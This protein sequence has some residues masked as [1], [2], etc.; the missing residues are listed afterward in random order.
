MKTKISFLAALIIF[1]TTI[2]AAI[3][4][5]M[6]DSKKVAMG[7][8]LNYTASWGGIT[9]GSATTKID[10][11]V[12]KLGAKNCYKIDV[13]GKTNGLARLFYVN[14]KWTSYIDTATVMTHKTFRSV[15]EGRYELDE[16]VYFD[17]KNQ[18]ADVRV[19]NKTSKT[20]QPK[21][22]YDTPECIRDVVAGFMFVRLV[23]LSRYKKGDVIVVNGFY[24]DEA[25]SMKIIL[26][27]S[28]VI[29]TVRGKVKCYKLKPL[30]P[31]NNLFNGQQAVSV[32][33]SDSTVPT[34]MQ[35]TAKMFVGSFHIELD[36]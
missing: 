14:D 2:D 28:E 30:I 20:Y 35:I 11:R 36:S 27:G 22:V 7:E 25:Y 10:P 18:K 6:A 1:A 26:D 19:Y 3:I 4:P 16:I 8:T 23:D 31:K 5:L 12:H 15:R 33:I 13:T 34:I 32:W 21:K 29:K 9:I 24:E 17:Q